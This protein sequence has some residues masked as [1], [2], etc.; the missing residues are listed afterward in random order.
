MEY[1]FYASQL[2]H[3]TSNQGPLLS[4]WDIISLIAHFLFH[5]VTNTYISE[6]YLSS[7]C[8]MGQVSFPIWTE[9]FLHKAKE[10]NTCLGTHNVSGAVLGDFVALIICYWHQVQCWEHKSSQYILPGLNGTTCCITNGP[11]FR[12]KF[13]FFAAVLTTCL[14]PSFSNLILKYHLTAN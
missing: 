13:S 11:E 12:K 3:M 9:I 8:D 6:E 5:L 10:T 4:T 2:L 7:G 14:F 1:F